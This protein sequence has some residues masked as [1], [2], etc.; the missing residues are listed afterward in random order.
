M[1]KA[2]ARELHSEQY[3]D[4]SPALIADMD[5]G[6]DRAYD[7]I[8]PFGHEEDQNLKGMLYSLSI[9]K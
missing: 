9:M 4:Y 8:S 5:N 3:G 2:R 1:L 6:E 7:G